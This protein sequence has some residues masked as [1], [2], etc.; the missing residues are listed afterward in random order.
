MIV[1]IPRDRIARLL[2]G[3]ELGDA[4]GNGGF[5][6]VLRGRQP[7]LQRDVAIK[8]L[9]ST[10]GQAS[11]DREAS[12]LAKMDHP[13]IVRV[14]HAVVEDDLC[15]IVM[16]LMD[17]GTLGK[18]KSAISSEGACA[19]GIAIAEALSYSHFRRVLHRDIKPGNVLF[20]ARGLPKV[21]DFGIAKI[22][23]GPVASDNSGVGTRQ[24][25]SPEQIRKDPIGRASDIYS[26]GVVLYELLTGNLPVSSSEWWPWQFGDIPRPAGVPPAVSDVIMRALDPDPQLRGDSAHEWA[27]ELAAAAVRSYGPDWRARSGIVL[28]TGEERLPTEVDPGKP[29]KRNRRVILAAA[30]ALAV[31]VGLIAFVVS[32]TGSGSGP[33]GQMAAGNPEPNDRTSASASA[34]PASPHPTSPHAGP[35]GPVPFSPTGFIPD[36]VAFSPDGTVLAVA[37]TAPGGGKGSTYLW[38]PATGSVRIMPDLGSHGAQAV[39][40]SPDGT[41]LA[42]GDADGDVYLWKVATTAHMT[43]HDPGSKGV[44]AVAFGPGGVLAAGDANG[45]TYLWNWKTGARVGVAL[46]DQGS[47]GVQSVAFSPDG[48]V[49][50]TGDGDGDVYLWRWSTGRHIRTLP[51]PSAPG[52]VEI[53]PDVQSVAFDPKGTVLAAGDANGNTYLWNWA[54]GARAGTLSDPEGES[55][56]AVAFSPDGTVLAVG[57]SNGST[58]LW[59]WAADTVTRTLHTAQET[60]G[61]SSVAF[62]RDGTAIAVGDHAGSTFVWHM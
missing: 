12:S 23:E 4:I 46:H 26:L 20:D 36:S 41:T 48:T 24:Y 44:Q 37:A 13:H 58:Y 51:D 1:E 52:V 3:Y 38:S 42:V 30:A 19:V 47:Q 15:L 60:H 49:L 62:S 25:M 56:Q 54:T 7:V 28:R 14:Y 33:S 10:T 16:E 11:F 39:A 29:P 17:G 55:V 57:D 35:A 50:A 31:V 21:A 43:L 22:L 8:V 59:N 53:S 9:Q 45:N 2:P 6:Y 5:G 18:R 34:R 40:F 27:M 61:V 32:S